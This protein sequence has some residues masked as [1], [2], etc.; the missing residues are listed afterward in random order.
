MTLS[1]TYHLPPALGLGI[2]PHAASPKSSIAFSNSTS[3]TAT[4]PGPLPLPLLPRERLNI[5][6]ELNYFDPGFALDRSVSGARAIGPSLFPNPTPLSQ[7]HLALP[8]RRVP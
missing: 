8:M 2:V 4:R 5:P 6:Q 1:P 7:R 3:P